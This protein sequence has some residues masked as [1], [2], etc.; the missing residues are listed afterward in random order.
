MRDEIWFVDK[1]A[2]RDSDIYLLEVCNVRFDQ[3]CVSGFDDFK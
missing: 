1:N 3:N 2:S